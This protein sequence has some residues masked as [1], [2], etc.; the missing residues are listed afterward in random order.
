MKKKWFGILRT[1]FS[2]ALAAWAINMVY[3]KSGVNGSDLIQRCRLEWVAA[4]LLIFGFG[5]AIASFRWCKLL[6]LQG[7]RV[8][9]WETFRLTMI[10]VFFN[11]F[12][13]G[14]VGG[15]ALKAVYVRAA[16]GPRGTEAILSILVDRILGLLGLF[17]VALS[18]LCLSWTEVS[19]APRDVHGMI[20]FVVAVALVGVGGVA[21]VLSRDLWFSRSAKDKL[22][23]FARHFPAKLVGLVATAVRSLD[24]Y[25]GRLGELGKALTLSVLVHT[26]AAASVMCLGHSLPVEGLEPRDYFLGVSIANTISAI[27]ITPGGL[28]SR[29]IVMSR[30]FTVLGG[31]GYDQNIPFLFSVVIVTWSLIGGIF[32]MT[33]KA[34]PPA[35]EETLA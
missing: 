13:F 4:S 19:A 7:V 11:L 20:S 25:R 10:G 23:S 5:N 6:E 8:G 27:P 28:G 34:A 30:F 21:A 29:D 24:L 14:G 31:G 35:P 26:L 1:L 17:I 22:R 12:G 18:A 9:Q 16:A 15:D 33:H 3:A 2:L 32:F